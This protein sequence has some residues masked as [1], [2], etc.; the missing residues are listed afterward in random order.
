VVIETEPFG[1]GIAYSTPLPLD[2]SGP[3]KF[4]TDLNSAVIRYLMPTVTFHE[5]IPGHHYR[6][7]IRGELQEGTTTHQEV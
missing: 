6:N 4:F 3:G 1:S 2:G 5:T 7:G